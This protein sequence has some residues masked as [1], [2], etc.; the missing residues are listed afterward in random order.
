MAVLVRDPAEFPALAALAAAR[1]RA[2]QKPSLE[3]LDFPALH[4]GQAAVVA[5][6][7]RFNVVCCGRRWGKTELSERL[8]AETAL[9]G[10][11]VAYIIPSYPMLT[12]VWASLVRRL[13]P[14]IERTSVQDRRLELAGGGVIDFWSADGG[15][16]RIR[17]R[18]YA[19]VVLDECAMMPGLID[20]W[21]L[22]VRP[23]LTDHQ[24]D[25]WFPS[26][27]RRGGGF[28]ELYRREE[29]DAEWRTWT[30][31]TWTSPHIAPEEIEAAR[32]GLSP[33]AFAQ[34]YGAEIEASESDL[35]Y[36]EFRA[37][38]HVKP[39]PCAWDE[40]TW[41]LAGIDPGGGDPTAIVMIGVS[42][43]GHAHQYGEF[44][45]RGDVTMEA[46]VTY[47]MDW[48]R[49]GPLA[50][51]AIDPS[52]KGWTATLQQYGIPA[53][54][55][56]NDRMAGFEVVRWFLNGRFTIGPESP[57]SIREFSTYRWAKRRDGESG[58]RYLT[59]TP[60]DHHADAHDARRYALVA[61]MRALGNRSRRKAPLPV[62]HRIPGKVD[63]TPA[64]I[65]RWMKQG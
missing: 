2:K 40:C 31:P 47:L 14:V 6:A 50:M 4:P 36:P 24:G 63:D 30:M 28:E 15:L 23:T 65:K 21:E 9:A 37:A 1:V 51:V 58:E 35:V 42:P 61:L 5:G 59:S 29:T 43:K 8:L 55:A 54:V 56:D 25:A 11:P 38:L 52:A 41:R 12:E 62:M 64:V 46:V 13:G 19:R 20:S 3:T 53:Q 22:A 45:R 10:L 49:R 34:E 57:E 7:C 32:A 16:D 33:Q 26:T 60:A 48:H 18:A 44:Y 27:P 17:G 39:A